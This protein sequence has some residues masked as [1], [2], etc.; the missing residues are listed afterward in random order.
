MFSLH[1]NSVFLFLPVF[2]LLPTRGW[3][4]GTLLDSGSFPELRDHAL[5]FLNFDV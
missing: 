3:G 5:L 4:A 1:G 2:D